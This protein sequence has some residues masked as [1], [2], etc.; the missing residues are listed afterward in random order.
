M[1][2]KNR[3][4]SIEFLF[5]PDCIEHGFMSVNDDGE[6]NDEEILAHLGQQFDNVDTLGFIDAETGGLKYIQISKCLAINAEFVPSPS[7]N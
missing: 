2:K 6:M 1:R 3:T 5:G 7:F 4:L